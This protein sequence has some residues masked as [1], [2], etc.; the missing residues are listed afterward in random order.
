MKKTFLIVSRKG[1]DMAVA[2]VEIDPHTTQGVSE[3]Q[4]ELNK[5]SKAGNLVMQ[6]VP[7][8]P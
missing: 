2:S 7:I 6:V 8:E 3:L 1:G 5:V 4:D